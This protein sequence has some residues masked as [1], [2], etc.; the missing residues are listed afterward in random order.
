[1]FVPQTSQPRR[2]RR[3][4]RQ[5][6]SHPFARLS[7][8]CRSDALGLRLESLSLLV[9]WA[10]PRAALLK[11]RTVRGGPSPTPL[12]WIARAQ[13]IVLKVTFG[14]FLPDKPPATRSSRPLTPPANAAR[15]SSSGSGFGRVGRQVPLLRTTLG[16]VCRS[17]STSGGG[18]SSGA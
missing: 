16:V 5:P 13:L 2:S 7:R 12:A 1:M 14:M 18:E 10:V 15:H 4:V 17:L 3:S 11:A 9:T 6:V 8:V